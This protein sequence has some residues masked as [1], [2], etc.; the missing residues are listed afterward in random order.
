MA[1]GCYALARSGEPHLLQGDRPRHLP[2]L[3]RAPPVRTAHRPAGRPTEPR[4]GDRS[5]RA[6]QVARTAVHV[7]QRR[8]ACWIA[9]GTHR[10]RCAAPPA[11]PPTPRSQINVTGHP[12]AG[13]TPYQEVR[14]FIDAHTHGMAFE[15]LG[16]DVHCGRPWRRTARRRA[17]GLPR[18][19]ADRRQRRGDGGVPVRQAARHDPVGW[20]TFKDWPA[21]ELADPRGHLLQVDGALLARRP[22]DPG[23]PARR[24]QQALR[25]LPAQ[26]Q[27]LRRHG[28][29]PAAGQGHARSSRTTSTRSTA[30]PAR[31]GTA[32]SPTRP[33]P[34]G[35]QRRQD[36]RGDGHRDLRAVRLH[37]RS[38]SV[39]DQCD[40][41]V[42]RQAARR[43]AR[44][45]A[46]RRW[47]WS[48][49]S[50]TPSPASP[51]TR[52]RPAR[53]STPPTSSRPARSGGCS[54][55]SPNDREVHDKDQVAAA[56]RS[57]AAQQ[58][59]LFGAIGK[60][61]GAPRAGAAGLPA[62]GTTAT[63]AA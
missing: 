17:R 62:A 55:A 34:A 45:W 14:G 24:E 37:D 27:L 33:G 16:G 48:T 25:A 39:P 32:S 63:A 18:P 15:F 19:H 38:S 13:V 59:A 4:P 52:A 2:A 1:G 60:L 22:A 40:A 58:D 20:P 50:T 23:Q 6:P 21:P 5:G 8:A 10:S 9:G 56:R 28:L 43:G 47:S 49:S 29:D 36:G 7:P 26:A 31:A 61:F 51:V 30:A 41:G 54:T 12:F 53:S 42:D 11:A 44:R 3:R 57:G 46:S 35:H